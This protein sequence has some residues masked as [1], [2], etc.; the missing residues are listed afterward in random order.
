MILVPGALHDAAVVARRIDFAGCCRRRRASPGHRPGSSSAVERAA[1]V[2]FHSQ[3]SLLVFLPIT[4]GLDYDFAKDLG[5]TAV[6]AD[7]HLAH[8][9][10]LVGHPVRARGLRPS[11]SE[12]AG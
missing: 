8:F 1:L 12:I 3:A 11:I 9:L 10:R 6:P 4:L 7:C 2:L 5:E